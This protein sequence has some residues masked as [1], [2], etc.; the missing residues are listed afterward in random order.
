MQDL[1]R[2]ITDLQSPYWW[3]TAVL[4]AVAVNVLSAYIKT[5]ID[6]LLTK[7]SQKRLAEME[8]AS[9]ETKLWAKYLL[10]DAKL[11]QLSLARLTSLQIEHSGQCALLIAEAVCIYAF[12][13]FPTSVKGVVLA[14]L[15]GVVMFLQLVWL[16]LV[17]REI[18]RMKRQHEAVEHWL[19]ERVLGPGAQASEPPE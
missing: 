15:V 3:A 17:S 19:Q 12:G 5:P 6:R 10:Q 9:A 8:R 16:S 14:I 1:E 7:R 4:L 13:T 2:L 11:L 18:A